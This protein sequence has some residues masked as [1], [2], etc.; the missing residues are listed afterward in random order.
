[1]APKA[2]KRID[3]RFLKALLRP[4]KAVLGLDTDCAGLLRPKEVEFNA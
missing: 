2:L 1:M 4:H 3:V